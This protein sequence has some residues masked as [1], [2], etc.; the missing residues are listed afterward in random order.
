MPV[1]S[2][3]DSPQ[4]QT[5]KKLYGI[6]YYFAIAVIVVAWIVAFRSY[7]ENYDSMH[8]EITW[9]VP[10]VQVD[11]VEAEGIFLWNET[12]LAASASGKVRYPKGPGPHKVAAGE[13][14]AR[15]SSGQA[16]YDVKAPQAGYFLAG[17][18]G[19]EGQ[20]KYADIWPGVAPLP[21]GGTVK[22]ARD[23][24]GVTKGNPVGKLIHQ[25][26]EL[27]FI[28]YTD[29]SPPLKD[30]LENDRVMVKMDPL[31]TPSRAHVRVY[32][33]IGHRAKIYLNLPW[34]P[35][36]I[37]LSRN[38]SLIIEAGETHGVVVPESAVATK[39]GVIGTYVLRGSHSVFVPLNGRTI[40]GSRYL[41]T[42]GLKLGD[43]VIV[44][45]AAAREGRVKLW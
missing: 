31:D 7:F 38:Y 9:V 26:Q 15:I 2:R 6:F 18:D 25:P 35:P 23:G 3:G 13:V 10:W 34:F 11:M 43:A 8:P 37:V 41:A 30:A 19:A 44:N 40:S 29:L 32:D 5:K 39:N 12:K 20:W 28:G 27:R 21:K 17:F 45:G 1:R 22:M 33:D 14:V 4:K 24:D 16:V 42:N 36:D